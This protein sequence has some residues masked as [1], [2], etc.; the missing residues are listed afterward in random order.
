MI[1]KWLTCFRAIS[2]LWLV[3]ADGTTGWSAGVADGMMSA[4]KLTGITVKWKNRSIGNNFIDSILPWGDAM[5][6]WIEDTT[7]AMIKPT[8]S[9]V[10]SCTSTD[11]SSD[12]GSSGW[13]SSGW[14][15][16]C[17]WGGD[18]T[19]CVWASGEEGDD[20]TWISD[21]RGGEEGGAVFWHFACDLV[22]LGPFLLA[23]LAWGASALVLVP[24]VFTDLPGCWY[25]NK[26]FVSTSVIRSWWNSGR[27]GKITDD[28]PIVA[29]VSWKDYVS[30][31]WNRNK[32]NKSRIYLE[33]LC[34]SSSSYRWGCLRSPG[35]DFLETYTPV[36]PSLAH[37][38]R[39]ERSRPMEGV[40]SAF[41]SCWLS[42]V[43]HR[44]N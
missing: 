23:W 40:W 41:R 26:S 12:W 38:Y 44:S 1:I 37:Y 5:L 35:G 34:R 39:S 22:L 29:D 14:G 33:S 31:E 13:G 2:R 8:G 15:S 11:V 7:N 36:P 10:C 21:T 3:E 20:S 16:S 24:L 32:L 30:M 19:C 27:N 43:Y 6:V 17:G 18:G 42:V 9:A 25:N 4:K 28:V